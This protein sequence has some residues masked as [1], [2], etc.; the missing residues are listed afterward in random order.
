MVLWRSEG[1]G[2]HVTIR[3]KLG[4]HQRAPCIGRSPREL[5]FIET[6]GGRVIVTITCECDRNATGRSGGVSLCS[7]YLHK[8]IRKIAQSL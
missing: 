2:Q 7:E 6:H 4:A 3:R 1:V 8:I 5:C